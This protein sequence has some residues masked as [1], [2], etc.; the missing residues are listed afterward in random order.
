MTDSTGAVV[1]N[2]TVTATNKDTGFKKS[3][4]S[5][6]DGNYVIVLL[7][8]GNYLVEVAAA[9]GFASARYD[10]VKVTVG[11]KYSLSIELAPAGT[12]NVVNVDASGE[13]VELTRTSIST[14]I[15]ENAV[16]NLPTNGRNFLDFAVLTPGIVRDPTRSG[17]L[18]VGGQKGTLNSIQIDG[19]SSDNTFFGQATGRIGSGRAPS[20]FSIDTVKEFQVNQNGFSAE[21]GRAA[22]AVINV[23]TKS[24]TNR[25]AASAFEYFRDESLNARNPNLVSAGRPR[26]AGQI[27]QFG[28]TF[29]G[30]IKKD[31]LFYFASYEQQRFRAPRQVL[32]GTLVG[33]T[34]TASQTEGFNF[35]R[36]LESQYTQ[37]NDAYAALGK[38]DW[39][40]NDVNRFN[41]RYNYSRNNAKNAVS[42]G[43][44]V[45]DP[46]TTNSL[47]TNGTEKNRNNIVV[48]QLVS[49]ISA[50][51][52]NEFKFQWARE[53]RPRI[54][55]AQVANVSTAIGV[56]GTRNFLP[57][58]QFDKRLQFA[59]SFTVLR[60]NHTFKFGGEFSNIHADQ[61]FGF[62][63]FGV[64]TFS[65]LTSTSGILD[66]ITS[67]PN[68]SA[69]NGGYF[70]RFDTTTARY[71]KQVGNLSAA[72]TVRELAFFGQDSWRVLPNLTFNIGLRFEKQYNPSAEAN[73]TA[74]INLIKSTTV[75]LYGKAIDPT[76]IPDSQNEWGPRVGFAWDPFKQGKTVIRGFSGMYYART[77]LIVLA[78][79]FNNF[80]DPAGD[81]SVTLGSPAFSSTG[82]NLA[83]FCSQNP[84]YV[85]TVGACV[86]PNTVFRQFAILGINLN[87][88]P[89]SNLPVLSPTQLSQIANAIR[90]ATTNPPPSLGIY[91]NANFV[92]IAPNFRNPQSFQFGGGFEHEMWKG[93][94]IGVDYSQIN[95]VYLQRNR[96]IN[97]PNPTGIEPQ[98]LRVLVN[99]SVRPLTQIGTIQ[100]RDSSARSLYRGLTFR[101]NMSRKWGRVN[102]FYTLAKTTSSDDNERDA[103]GV[104]YD[105]PYDLTT[106]YGPARFDRRH[107]FVANPIFFLPYGF[108]VS[109]AVRLY[110]G[111]PVN[112]RVGSDINGD[113]NT[114]ERPFLVPGYEI[115]RNAFEGR[116]FYQV[117]LRLQKGFKFGERRRLVFSS[118]FFNVFNNSNIE[119]TSTTSSNYCNNTAANCG[120]F[121]P[122]N[123]N[124]LQVRERN[125]LSSLFNQIL[126]ANNPRSQ[127][128]QVQFGAR[129]SF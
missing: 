4:Q 1:P 37:T 66:A 95:T 62:N 57:T 113:G 109:S 92:G 83:T 3:V 91:Q 119:I 58:T 48:A 108:Q 106:E 49:T 104:L 89:L 10:N 112:A 117:D 120:L 26:P 34:P 18:A 94:K 123:V 107:Q 122:T 25:F 23:V 53:D 59:D 68:P 72:F 81:L 42:T 96:D 55:N 121:G 101:M 78:A 82:F 128:F 124:F 30:P 17:D 115:H 6:V 73:N 28:G 69:P 100:I 111:I 11:S 129:F 97:L 86:T 61:K 76:Q 105:N 71:N 63:Q 80:R 60:G 35:Y 90:N 98:T 65:G 99:R 127:V 50:S 24:G 74:V 13:S 110:S 118:E 31:K 2:V 45:L 40:I 67:T 8:P 27:N 19:A 125:P 43:E 93:V 5:D 64:F 79:P 33:F 52:I 46:T 84:T 20:Q 77:P 114:N 22:G 38:I 29:G 88:A 126:L 16:R 15:N 102:A 85:T 21:F 70:G 116:P 32:Y 44:T 47:A 54:P 56:Y 51:I 39:N 41:I 75:P 103:G 14:T 9:K 87:S 36:G 7:P 12:Q